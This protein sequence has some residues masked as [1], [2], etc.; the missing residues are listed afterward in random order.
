[1]SGAP[2][3]P[4]GPHGATRGRRL[5]LAIRIALG[6]WLAWSVG[7]AVVAPELSRLGALT[8]LGIAAATFWRPAWG[9]VA[10]VALVPAGALYA[11][12]PA[13]VA[14]W[15]AWAFL[16]SWLLRLWRPLRSNAWPPAISI[17]AVLFGAAMVVSWTSL[18]VAGAVG[19]PWTAMPEF[20]FQSLSRDYLIF[21][22]PEAETWTL[23]Q[24]LT[25][26]GLFVAAVGVTQGEPRHTRSLALALMGSLTALA[27]ATPLEVVRQWAAT[28][29]ADWFLTR[30][31]ERG[32]RFSIHMADVNA[33]GS[34]YILA[35]TIAVAHVM[36]RAKPRAVWIALS[37]LLVPALWLAGSRSAYL[38]IAGG[39]A[40]LATV[41][42][43][44]TRRQAF[45]L[46][47]AALL[48][49]VALSA[50][51]TLDR[52]ADTQGG[53][54]QSANLRSQFLRTSARMFASSPLSGVGIGRYFERSAEF[55]TPALREL[56]GNENAHNYFAQQFSELGL[57]GGL[58]FLWL[59][60]ATLCAGWRWVRDSPTDT[61]ALALL[62]GTSG[63]LLTCATGH[64]LLVPEAALPFWV[65]FG[66]VA[67]AARHAPATLAPRILA[68]V[69]C[70]ALA[71]GV[72]RATGT[73][74]RV[75]EPPADSGFHGLEMDEDDTP[76]RWMTRHSVTYI[77]DGPGFLRL[78][79]HAPNRPMPRPLI[80]ETSIAGRVADRR[81][82]IPGD[83]I[84]VD[85]PARQTGTPFRRV[86]FRANQV[87]TE[88]VRLGQ[89]A[90]RRPIT[91]MAGAITWMPLR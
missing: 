6:G 68:L 18:T 28:G 27:I 5:S 74:G 23:L 76:F 48:L 55:M 3:A 13:R 7:L 85:I 84:T 20:F 2:P 1:V 15:F 39:L 50:A 9:L 30:F 73:R 31:T 35:C 10:T 60:W 8:A 59:I 83:W 12:A 38:G 49:V 75:T 80:L 43:R 46:A 33:A 66:A 72:W 45:L 52:G 26:L 42:H 90:A 64:P 22:G 47:G 56:Y 53:V 89:R 57:T 58:P 36:G 71:A 69:T 4:S 11:P 40:M 54:R 21:S 87:W 79:L 17:P 70:L 32:E 81:D 63:Y 16:A 14:E 88:E 44:W 41:R 77:P 24:S 67:G 34:L 78:R 82:V 61:A 62:A 19:V 29:Y 51:A 86:D 91:V 25:G 65:V 37:G